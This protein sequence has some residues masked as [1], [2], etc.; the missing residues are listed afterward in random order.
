MKRPSNYK[1]WAIGTQRRNGFHVRRIV[2]GLLMAQAEQ[3][4]GEEVRAST[5]E[6]EAQFKR[7]QNLFSQEKR[8]R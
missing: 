3:R 2:W 4:D 1:V 8:M 7:R 5:I 6:V